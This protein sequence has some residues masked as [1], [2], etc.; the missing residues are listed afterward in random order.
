MSASGGGA[1]R[2]RAIAVVRSRFEPLL[3]DRLERELPRIVTDAVDGQEARSFMALLRERG[4]LRAGCTVLDVGS[5]LGAF[6]ALARNEG[7]AA[8]GLE[9]SMEDLLLARSRP[10]VDDGAFVCGVAERLPFRDGTFDLVT[11]FNTIE[12]VLDPASAIREAARVCRPGGHVFV[13]APNYA[14][15][16]SEPHYHVAWIPWLPRGAYELYLRTRGRDP[17]FLSTIRFVTRGSVLRAATRAGLRARASLLDS[18]KWTSPQHIERSW[19]RAGVRAL[20]VTR[21]DRTV[22]A[23]YLRLPRQGVDF[24]LEKGEIAER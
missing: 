6:V 22:R 23:L 10:G 15:R 14:F 24:L 12:H 1:W 21:L 16:L 7:H 17:G 19:L 3:G 20:R 8:I 18:E 9:L 5:G 2:E 13:L 11:L 4:A